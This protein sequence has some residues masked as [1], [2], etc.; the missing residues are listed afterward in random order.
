MPRHPFKPLS[1]LTALGYLLCVW[2]THGILRAFLIFRNDV[3]GN[4]FV[5]KWD[6]YIFHALCI[7][8]LW[9]LTWSLPFLVL[10]GLAGRL[11]KVRLYRVLFGLLVTFHSL[12]L[13]LTVSDHETYRFLGMHLRLTIFR[14]YVNPAGARDIFSF[15]AS[16]KSVKYLPF[17]L[18]MLCVPVSLFLFRWIK[19]RWQ[20]VQGGGS[21]KTVLV[22]TLLA[23]AISYIFLNHI[24]GG[25]FRRKRLE[26]ILEVFIQD[27]KDWNA[28]NIPQARLDYL[29]GAFQKQWYNLSADSVSLDSVFIDNGFIFTDVK[30]P[31]LK[32]PVFDYC[33]SPA[34]DTALCQ[35]DTDGDTYPAAVDC[36]DRDSNTYPGAVD[37]PGNGVDENCDGVDNTPVNMV[38]VF[39][40]SHRAINCGFLKPWGATRDATP[41]LNKLAPASHIWPRFT[42]NGLPTIA[43]L[44]SAH[45]SLPEHPMKHI[46]TEF[47]GLEHISFTQILRKY[48]YTTSY[49]SAADPS[50][51]GQTPWLAKWYDQYFYDRTREE[52]ALMFDHMGSWMRTPGNLKEPFLI[53][54][55]TKTNHFPFNNTP[56]ARALPPDATLQDKMVE[57]MKYTENALKNF[58]ES[59]K[60][61][62]WYSNTIFVI[63]ADHGFPINEHGSSQIGFGLYTESIWVPFLI[64]G[65]HPELGAPA[66]HPGSA[67]Q[68]DI[69][70]TLLDLAG[71]T[72]TNHFIGKSLL[73]SGVHFNT[74]ARGYQGFIEFGPYRAHDCLTPGGCSRAPEL[75][76]ILEDRMETHNLLPQH[77][78]AFD[79]AITVMRNFH[80]LNRWA[81]ENN[82]LMPAP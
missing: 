42:V 15:I 33:Q 69:A 18:F 14:T 49:F 20:W 19:H 43:A 82:R 80:E 72:H 2:V 40:E 60:D 34:A 54:A 75:F 17:L 56:G 25:G 52:D 26:P 41:W 65:S 1:L 45:L 63:M 31:F 38:L 6:W 24:W 13:L 48:G 50:W 71:I 36:D 22:I 8:M 53:S 47:A 23:A 29:R 76:N 78:S 11:N 70:P 64:Y 30:Y 59:I 35:R 4:P 58:M 44:F 27:I 3:Y 81:I 57:S 68:M 66:L 32:T 79:S 39:L 5:G 46:A 9:I 62:A 73:K 28:Y 77:Q 67:S 21:R 74:G 37:A 55:I 10:I 16:D 61:E 51:D 12:V 7:D